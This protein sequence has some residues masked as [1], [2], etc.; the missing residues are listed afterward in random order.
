MV[1]R[2]WGPIDEISTQHQTAQGSWLVDHHQC[3][4]RHRD[5]ESTLE[6][7]KTDPSSSTTPLINSPL[8][9]T[10]GGTA[11]T[12]RDDAPHRR[13]WRWRRQELRHL[14][15][16]Y[17]KSTQADR[18]MPVQ[19]MPKHS[20]H[21]TVA[22]HPQEQL[23]RFQEEAFRWWWGIWWQDWQHWSCCRR[24]LCLPKLTSLRYMTSGENLCPTP[25]C[26]RKP[27]RVNLAGKSV[28]CGALSHSVS[29]SSCQMHTIGDMRA[30]PHYTRVTLPLIVQMWLTNN[31][32]TQHT[33]VIC[34]NGPVLNAWYV[35][36]SPCSTLRGWLGKN[37]RWWVHRHG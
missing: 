33:C 37:K 22:K 12:Q 28:C 35:M 27:W 3:S 6:R 5:S 10:P 15:L 19:Q 25:P 7:Y 11:S 34:D 14:I 16:A 29:L 1:W 32:A 9:A 30:I 4:T 8:N 26:K 18:T 36:M 2:N 23:G 31:N 17:I 24:R 21:G 13:R 20:T